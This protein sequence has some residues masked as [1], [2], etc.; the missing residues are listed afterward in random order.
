MEVEEGEEVEDVAEADGADSA[1]E[2]RLA[3]KVANF[4]MAAEGYYTPRRI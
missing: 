1:V 2:S 3:R 4:G